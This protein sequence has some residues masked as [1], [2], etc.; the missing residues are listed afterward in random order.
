MSQFNPYANNGGTIAA[1]GGKG[2]VVA[3]GD[4][5][6]SSGY[7]IL[8]RDQR[9]IFKI[10]DSNL[11]A[12]SGCWADCLTFVKN[13][14]IRVKYYLYDH[15]KSISTNALGA[16]VSN[17]LYSKRMFPY[18]VGNMVCGLDKNNEGIIYSYDPVGSYEPLK[19]STMG[20]SSAMIMPFLDCMVKMENQTIIDD[21]MKTISVE[22]A[23]TILKDAFISASERD[24]QTGDSLQIVT[25]T[26]QGVEEEV[27]ELRKD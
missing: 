10:T 25:L 26:P 8:T 5:R 27:F 19:Y 17:M 23:K 22:R 16:L 1:I 24:I 4:T 20:S 15:N 12:T 21:E 9:K 3:A 6:L 7:T 11:F 18:Y 13:L 14:Q 2:F